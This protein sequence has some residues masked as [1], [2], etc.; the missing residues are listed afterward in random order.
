MLETYKGHD[1]LATKDWVR[2]EPPEDWGQ[3]LSDAKERLLRIPGETGPLAE[4]A[5]RHRALRRP[6]PADPSRLHGARPDMSRDGQ[7]P[8]HVR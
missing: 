4:A 8:R 7:P 1:E 3:L 6:G 2:L 5:L